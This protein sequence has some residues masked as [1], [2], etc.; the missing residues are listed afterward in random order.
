MPLTLGTLERTRKLVGDGEATG[1]VDALFKVIPSFFDKTQNIRNYGGKEYIFGTAM[2]ATVRDVAIR[3][4][5]EHFL[6]NISVR[7]IPKE[8]FDKLGYFT[9]W[10][11]TNYG[12]MVGL[13]GGFEV[14]GG[15]A[16][17][18]FAHVFVEFGWGAPLFWFVLGS[19]ALAPVI[20]PCRRN[21]GIWPGSVI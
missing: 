5:T 17:T 6:Y 4:N 3:M 1:R 18:G 11:N 21:R 7:F 20:R 16:P 9:R 12:P 13:H 2:V 15:A 8:A 10:N 19:F 14:P